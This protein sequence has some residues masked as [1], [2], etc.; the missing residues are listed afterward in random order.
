M[1]TLVPHD[2]DHAGHDHAHGHPGSERAAAVRRAVRLNRISIGYNVVEAGVALVA[3][4]AAGSISLL[5]FG[6]DSVVEV[7][8]SVALAWRLAAERRDGCTQGSDRRAVKVIALSFLALAAYVGYGAT[9]VLVTHEPPEASP[10]GIVLTALSLLLMPFLARAKRR[11]APALGSRAQ[12]AE[13]AQTSICALLSAVVLAGLVLN[14]AAGWWWADPVAA[15]GV[16][17][18]AA[19]EGVRTWRADSLADTCCA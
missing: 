11:V 7:S 9:A 5:G 16:A 18:V 6:L 17:V 14:A 2:H 3:G 4:L 8:A 12:E 15:L 10:V 1:S 13:A 19:V